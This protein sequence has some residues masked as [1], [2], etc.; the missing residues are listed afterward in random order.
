MTSFLTICNDVARESGTFPD[1]PALSTTVDQTGRKYDLV[2]WVK[3]AYEDVQR[4]QRAWRWLTTEFSG[5]TISGSREYTASDMSITER[6]GHWVPFNEF[7]ERSVSIYKTSEGQAKEQR[8][9]FVDQSVF[10]S[11]Y[12]MGAQATQTGRP[13]C[14]TIDN[15]NRLAFYPTPDAAYTVRGLYYKSPQVLATDAEDPEMPDQFHRLIQ[16]DALILLGTFDEAFNQLQ[17]WERRSMSL[18]SHLIAD[19][20][21]TIR[22]PGPLA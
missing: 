3:Q 6:F 9:Q 14:Y 20:S 18:M 19:Q 7:N 5:E 17:L 1:R 4:S 21:P 16:W 13:T 15:Q 22:K 2:E 8:L 10:R 12:G 11:R